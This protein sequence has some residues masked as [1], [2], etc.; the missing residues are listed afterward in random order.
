MTLSTPPARI[1]SAA[2]AS[3]VLVVINPDV[4]GL[5]DLCLWEKIFGWCP[6]RGMTHALSAFFHGDWTS[7]V[8][9]NPGIAVVVPVAA[10]VIIADAVMIARRSSAEIR[11]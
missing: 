2:V 3:L 8:R 4:P 11:G 9:Y 7:A 6:A 1:V 5:P 10:A